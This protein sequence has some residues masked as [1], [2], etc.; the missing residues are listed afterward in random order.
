[1]KNPTR[2]KISKKKSK[3]YLRDKEKNCQK[4]RKMKNWKIP[5]KNCE[6][7]HH[8]IRYEKKISMILSKKKTNLFSFFTLVKI[9][10]NFAIRIFTQL[11]KNHEEKPKKWEFKKNTKPLKKTMKKN[12]PT[13][14][15]K[16]QLQY[17]ILMNKKMY[18]LRCHRCLI[19]NYNK[20]FKKYCLSAILFTRDS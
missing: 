7:T 8:S 1:M 15:W 13:V 20:I 12:I 18:S 5:Q 14:E 16:K 9:W 19:K 6:K 4:N 2:K 17:Y 11:I 3:K 10:E